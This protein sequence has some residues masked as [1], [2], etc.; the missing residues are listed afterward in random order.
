MITEIRRSID[1]IVARYRLEPSLRDILVE[2]WFDAK[3]LRWYL[4]SHRAAD[5]VIYDVSTID[6]PVQLLLDKQLPDNARSRVI[7]TAIEYCNALGSQALSL[8]CI[9]DRDFD[10]P[11]TATINCGCL[12]YTD[13]SSMEMY[14]FDDLCLEKAL[15]L[16]LGIDAKLGRLIVADVRLILIRL[17]LIRASNVYLGWGMT[18]YEPWKCLEA[19]KGTITFREDEHI[20][21]YLNKNARARDMQVF[22]SKLD[23]LSQVEFDDY[24][25]SIRGHDAFEVLAWALCAATSKDL[26]EGR[27][28]TAIACTS[29]T[30]GQLDAFPLFQ[31]VKGRVLA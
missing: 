19:V 12:L 29:I 25:R 2:G 20:Q 30:V 23:E 13:F 11:G 5:I 16:G 22:K 31:A 18:W 17:F 24:R 26:C 7:Y 1:E 9:I 10:L 15:T 3:L 27:A 14:L 6:V 4:Q 8:T 28:L 21:R